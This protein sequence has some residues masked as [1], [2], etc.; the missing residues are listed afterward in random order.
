MSIPPGSVTQ[1]DTQIDSQ[2]DA[3]NGPLL[4]CAA[5]TASDKQAW[6]GFYASWKQLHN[7]WTIEDATGWMALWAG[8]LYIAG[9][10]YEQMQQYAAQ[11][12][13]WQQKTAAACPTE[14]TVPAPIIQP[15]PKSGPAD[16]ESIIKV[17]AA[18]LTTI[19][20]A[21]AAWKG[22]TIVEDFTSNVRK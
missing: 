7:F 15:T 1:L 9:S 22:L 2:M 6:T 20:I 14:Y 4:A 21:G 13:S 18:A 19:A 3:L 11:L 12:P 17:A 8:E 10:I 5:I 16:W